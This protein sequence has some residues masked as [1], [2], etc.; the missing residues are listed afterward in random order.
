MITTG[1]QTSAPEPTAKIAA[2]EAGKRDSKGKASSA[3]AGAIAASGEQRTLPARKSGTS[4]IY[5]G[6]EVKKHGDG[7]AEPA[8]GGDGRRVVG[9][10]LAV[11]RSAD[12]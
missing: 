9:R 10:H 6:I 11:P 7:K 2:P 1:R 12:Y 5:S 3:N 4:R 8:H